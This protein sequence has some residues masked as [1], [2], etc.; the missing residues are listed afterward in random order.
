MESSSV[1]KAFAH[2]RGGQPSPV[3]WIGIAAA[4]MFVEYLT[5]PAIHLAVWYMLPIGLAAWNDGWRWALPLAL[6]MPLIRFSFFL[7]GLWE[8]LTGTLHAPAANAVSR[9]GALSLLAAIVSHLGRKSRDASRQVEQLQRIREA[10]HHLADYVR[11]V[12]SP[13]K[14]QLAAAHLRLMAEIVEEKSTLD[15]IGGHMWR[16]GYPEV[17]PALMQQRKG[18]SA[19]PELSAASDDE[20][21]W[22]HLVRL[23]Q[24]GP[25]ELRR[26]GVNVHS[27]RG[28]SSILW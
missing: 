3:L 21:R 4:L 12:S 10:E 2:D 14:E 7:S 8:S 6:S 24:L 18:A 5:G 13:E 19:A 1:V 9:I 25:V 26:A 15:A 22:R 23:A 27:D 20:A 17:V 16:F 28:G 11:A